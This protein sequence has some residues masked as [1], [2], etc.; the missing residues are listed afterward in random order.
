MTCPLSPA[1]RRCAASRSTPRAGGWRWRLPRRSSATASASSARCRPSASTPPGRARSSRHDRRPAFAGQDA[2]GEEGSMTEHAP[3][4]V[5]ALRAWIGRSDRA[6]DL[7]T[8]HLVQGLLATLD[9]DG[10]AP[11]EGQPAP[12]TVHWCLTQPTVPMSRLGPDGHPARGGFLPP[13]PLPR[14][15]W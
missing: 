7:V 2:G 9:Q 6:T 12:T 15:M 4:D 5:A 1:T 14:R 8:P 3:L 11:A 13:V 10:L